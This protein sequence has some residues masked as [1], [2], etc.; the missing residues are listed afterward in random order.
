MTGASPALLE[1]E[2]LAFGLFKKLECGRSSVAPLRVR[3]EPLS[4]EKKHAMR[5]K[6]RRRGQIGGESKRNNADGPLSS[7]PPAATHTSHGKTKREVKQIGV[8]LQLGGKRGRQCRTTSYLHWKGYVP[9]QQGL[10]LKKE[11]P[12]RQIYR[13]R[14]EGDSYGCAFERNSAVFP[15]LGRERLIGEGR[16]LSG[17]GEEN[18]VC[19]K[20]GRSDLE[21]Q[22]GEGVYL[23]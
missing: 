11:K 20:L 16:T 19:Q 21:E 9:D 22:S 15:I 5:E 10:R 8:S 2:G 6:R 13:L 12:P 23:N 18:K 17:R 3:G 14:L 1:R 4:V 7:L